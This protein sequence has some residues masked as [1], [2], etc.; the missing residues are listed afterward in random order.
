MSLLL[1][2]LAMVSQAS[3]TPA[4]LLGRWVNPNRTVIMVIAQCGPKLCGT[5]QW[6]SDK[7]K[8]DARLG[9]SQ[10][11]GAQLLTGVK[12]VFDSRWQGKLFVPDENVETNARLELVGPGQ[13]KVSGCW[14]GNICKWQVWTRMLRLNGG[15]SSRR[16]LN[17]PLLPQSSSKWVP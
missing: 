5:V 14:I 9:T 4:P 11:V 2:T 8:A 15:R 1:A 13:V 12:P 16:K 7:A 6:A 3:V 17:E 10:L